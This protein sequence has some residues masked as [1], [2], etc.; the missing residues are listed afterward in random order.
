MTFPPVFDY[1]EF[2]TRNLGFVSEAEQAKLRA[3]QVF[4]AGVGGMGGACVQA[5]ARAGVGRLIIADIDAFEV[6]NLNRQVFA[7]LTTVGRGKAEATAEALRRINPEIELEVLGGDWTE[8]LPDIAAR[9][10]II[11]NGCDDIPA[12]LHLYRTARAAG[13]T[14][15]DAYAAPLPSVT[16]VS[17]KDPRPEERLGYPTRHKG[18]R[19]V[20]DEEAR[21]AFMREIE[22]VLTH[23]SSH[24]HVDVQM[25]AEMAA[26]TRKRM[27]F[28]PMVITTGCLMAYEAL[29]L[30]MERKSR[31]DCRGWFFNPYELKVERP[32]PAPLAAARAAMVRRYMAK[33]LA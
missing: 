7:D 17:P 16:R 23:S 1:R 30:A 2:T 27:S 18:W 15:I 31:T 22:Y 8:R 14:V 26:G 19:E 11:V 24:R 6:S 21:A 32:L 28:A 12:T 13:A 10:K 5:L 29:S 4:V 20:T 25:A 3:A 9:C 33:L